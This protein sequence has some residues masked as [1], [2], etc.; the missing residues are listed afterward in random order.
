MQTF[1]WGLIGAGAAMLVSA[2]LSAPPVQAGYIVTLEQ[3]GSN[4]I[5]TGSGA[6]DPTGLSSLGI[7]GGGA[8][9]FPNLAAITTG[10]LEALTDVY[11]GFTGP[12]SFGSGGG[13]SR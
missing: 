2:G 13:L 10:P 1:R 6:I 11:I 3:V 5:A 8:R 4:V 9:M 12:T 7:G